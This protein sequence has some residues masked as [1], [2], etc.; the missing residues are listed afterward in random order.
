M[1]VREAIPPGGMVINAKPALSVGT[2]VTTL[3]GFT[4]RLGPVLFTNSYT[5]SII[6]FSSSKEIVLSDSG[7][8]RVLYVVGISMF[9]CWL[10]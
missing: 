8:A 3:I 10:V 7:R 2:S 9:C 5:D 4:T 1:W 6:G